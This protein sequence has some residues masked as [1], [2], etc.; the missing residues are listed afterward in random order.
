M[1]DKIYIVEME[2]NRETQ[3]ECASSQKIA[4]DMKNAAIESGKCKDWDV[5]TYQVTLDH[6]EV[7]GEVVHFKE[8]EPEYR[9]HPMSVREIRENMDENGFVTGKVLVHVSEMVNFDIEELMDY[10]SESL[11]GSPLLSD[12]DYSVAGAVPETNSIIIEVTGSVELVL[13][14]LEEEE[15]MDYDEG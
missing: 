15:E 8:D 9:M 12:V 3:I 13:A 5:T 7:A 11:V 1:R 6:M 2:V 10:L 4:E 14:E